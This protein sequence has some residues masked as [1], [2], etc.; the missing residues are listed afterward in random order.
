M[1]YKV[2]THDYRPPIQGG[3]PI[4][5]GAPGALLPVVPLD[6]TKNACGTHG[7]WHYCATI[8]DALDIAGLWPDGWPSV[9]AEVSPE[10]PVIWSGSKYRTSSLRLVRVV[11]EEEVQEGVYRLSAPFG[12]YQDDMTAEQMQ[13]RGALSRPLHDPEAVDLHLHVALDARGL[14]WILQQFD[15]R[16]AVWD[17]RIAWNAQSADAAWHARAAWSKGTTWNEGTAW[18]G[19]PWSTRAMWAPQATQAMWETRNVRAAWQMR[20]VRYMW[21][22]GD[23]SDALLVQYAV[24]QGWF[25]A[26]PQLLTLGIQDAYAAGLCSAGPTGPSTLGWAMV[27]IE[28]TNESPLAG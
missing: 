19:V 28:E 1:P 20:D 9:V 24:R 7:G 11:P 22:V 21:A 2:L 5:D 15:T 25:S 23:A 18:V 26:D 13:W 12:P 4:W 27:P 8:E 17:A 10:G 3:D 14:P 6:T 16:R